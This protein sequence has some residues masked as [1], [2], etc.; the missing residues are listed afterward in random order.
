MANPV[1]LV[2]LFKNV[3]PRLAQSLMGVQK[4][5][6]S[7]ASLSK[8]SKGMGNSEIGKLFT[9]LAKS[10]QELAGAE[11][12]ISF[13]VRKATKTQ[14]AS[15]LT[16]VITKGKEVVA[17]IAST[18]SPKGRTIGGN[19]KG[20]SF[21][22]SD[23]IVSNAEKFQ[24]LAKKLGINLETAQ[25]RVQMAAANGIFAKDEAVMAD[26]ITGKYVPVCQKN[27]AVRMFT[28]E[29]YHTKYDPVPMDEYFAGDFRRAFVQE[30]LPNYMKPRNPNSKSL[31][32]SENFIEDIRRKHGAVYTDSPEPEAVLPTE[33]SH[34]A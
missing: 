19:I 6:R 26:I 9:E 20:A 33:Y 5:E 12:V 15:I 22:Y 32:N 31:K 21:Y 24:A 10:G 2:G 1:A 18:I 23:K 7:V 4:I 8:L 13:T 30:P 17:K 29:V 28:P 11:G 14:D 25:S 3:S 34:R 27:N 16:A